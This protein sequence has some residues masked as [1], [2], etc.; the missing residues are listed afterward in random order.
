MKALRMLRARVRR[1]ARQVRRSA[2]NESGAVAA[3]VLGAIAAYAAVAASLPENPTAVQRRW[4]VVALI[5]GGITAFLTAKAGG[6][7]LRRRREGDLLEAPSREAAV[8]LASPAKREQRRR[9]MLERVRSSWIR[10][11]LNRS[12]GA[13]AQM[14]LGLRERPD[15]IRHP[16]ELVHWQA[17]QRQTIA[18]GTPISRV[19]DDTGKALLILGDPGSGKT[20]LLLEL[21]RELLDRARADPEHPIPVVFN[22]SSWSVRQAPL[23]E[24]LKIELVEAYQIPRNIAEEW[25]DADQILPLLDGL[26][27]VS[28]YHRDSCVEA[29][30]GFRDD[31]GLLPIAVC[32]RTQNYETLV[33]KL[34]LMGAVEIQPLTRAQVSRYLRQA[35]TPLAGV[36]AVLGDDETLWELLKSPLLL[37]IVVLAYQGKSAD[38]VRAA[39]PPEERRARLLA[40]YVE[41][42]LERRPEDPRFPRARTIHWLAWLASSLQAHEQKEFHVEWIQVDWLP[43]PGQRRLVTSGLPIAAAL[44]GG[45]IAAVVTRAIYHFA[46]RAYGL[47]GRAAVLGL[48]A[49]IATGLG[50]GF[51]I[52]LI[53]WDKTIRPAEPLRWTWAAARRN[54]RSRLSRGLLFGVIAGLVFWLAGGLPIESLVRVAF[55]IVPASLALVLYLLLGGLEGTML[56]GR[57]SPNE[58]MARARRNAVV[59]GL[60]FAL[61]FGLLTA[62]LYGSQYGLA[63]GLVTGAHTT[64]PIWVLAGLWAGGGAYLRHLAVRALLWRDGLASWNYV[65][66]LDYA[67]ERVLLRKVGGGY[68]FAHGSL[69]DHF[70]SANGKLVPVNFPSG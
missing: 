49:W 46:D 19:F 69:L 1:T 16:A 28:S 39:G 8:V 57:T 13:V 17:G 30:N 2:A 44:L 56:G 12:L 67:A 66:F 55:G 52:G 18:R 45:G 34:R 47:S 6:Y 11:S 54:L 21:T 35:G 7:S 42:M 14:E 65:T 32:S 22:L 50:I 36:C 53:L 51:A 15:A 43:T 5:G 63:N 62:I 48:P 23:S 10:E 26:D 31:H 20:T 29:I 9:A 33:A 24:W 60:P 38:A 61:P 59:G 68:I 41:R 3:A 70:A 25:V 40:D 64:L 58:G 4:A 37:N 27:E